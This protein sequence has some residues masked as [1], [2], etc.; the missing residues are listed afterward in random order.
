M[1]QHL[2][3]K[4]NQFDYQFKES[5]GKVTIITDSALEVDIMLRE[6]KITIQ[7]HLRKYNFLTGLLHFNITKVYTYLTIYLSI[8]ALSAFFD[9]NFFDG[10][11][12]FNSNY[13][14]LGLFVFNFLFIWCCL[15]YLKYQADFNSIKNQ[16]VS[17]F[18]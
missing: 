11:I 17:F 3:E 12:L 10:K 4:L 8:F 5:N 1:K 6:G 13:G 18:P 14:F 9:F 2:L 15:T 16:I 7:G